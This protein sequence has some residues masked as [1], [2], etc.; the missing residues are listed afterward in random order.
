MLKMGDHPNMLL[1]NLPTHFLSFG[2]APNH[3]KIQ[4]NKEKYQNPPP[5]L[6][7]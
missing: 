5:L 1:M 7:Y 2:K 4:P 6:E 3:G